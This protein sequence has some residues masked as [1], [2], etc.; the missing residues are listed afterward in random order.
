[1]ITINE[2]LNKDFRV[3]LE[4]NEETGVYTL[5]SESMKDG[6]KNE[7]F[8]DLKKAKEAFESSLTELKTKAVKTPKRTR[9]LKTALFNKIKEIKEK[10]EF[11]NVM[12]Y[13][14]T[15]S[16]KT[17]TL[18]DYLHQSKKKYVKIVMSSGFEDTDLLGKISID[19]SGATVYQEGVLVK[20][21]KEARDKGKE[22][23]IVIDEFNRASAKTLN[24]LIPLLDSKNGMSRLENFI[25]NEIIEVPTELLNFYFTA[26]IGYAGVDSIDSALLNRMDIVLSVDYQKDLEEV[27]VKR[28]TISADAKKIVKTITKELRNMYAQT[29]LK[30]PFSTRSLSR[31]I[32][33]VE[34]YSPTSTK[35]YVKLV[36]DFIID[37]LCHINNVGLADKA[38][39]LKLLEEEITPSKK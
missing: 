37:Q 10:L 30:E 1:M 29:L 11:K 20:T 8:E 4:L 26:N 15:G 13:G 35:E 36:D 24:L 5:T 27:F 34:I 9:S 17:H 32:K 22:V 18:E 21:L 23:H 6:A 16:G 31:L 25:N 39:V 14:V 28:S 19:K 3:I 7:E 38:D 2:I 33:L 12:L